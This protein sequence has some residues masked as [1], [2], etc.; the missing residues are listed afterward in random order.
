[1]NA[2]AQPIDMQPDFSKANAAQY[3]R[4]APGWKPRVNKTFAFL[5]RKP[6]LQWRAKQ[7]RVV[8]AKIPLLQ[9]RAKGNAIGE[10]HPSTIEKKRG[11][12]WSVDVSDCLFTP[13]ESTGHKLKRKAKALAHKVTHAGKADTSKREAAPLDQGRSMFSGAQAAQ[14]EQPAPGWKPRVQGKKFAYLKRKPA[15]QWRFQRRRVARSKIPLH[16]LR[17]QKRSAALGA[18]QQQQLLVEKK[19]GVAWTVDVSDC[20]LKR[21]ET[22]GHKL[23]RKAQEFVSAVKSLG[24]KKDEKAAAKHVQPE[25][26][27]I[28]KE[29]LTG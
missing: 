7:R 10:L 5:K 20:I 19:R 9:L 2:N 22:V 3:E 15:L 1:M 12:A 27:A 8:H 24:Q 18:G 17:L 25:Q 21:K 29:H 14:Y 4:P 13:K 11:T 6:A 23:K 26:H 16:E 28:R